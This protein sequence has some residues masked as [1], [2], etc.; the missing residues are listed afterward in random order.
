[1]QG[2]HLD[3]PRN[4]TELRPGFSEHRGGRAIPG[5]PKGQVLSGSS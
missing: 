3:V 1:M 4:L 5:P 2:A